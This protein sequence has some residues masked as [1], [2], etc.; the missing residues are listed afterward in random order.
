LFFENNNFILARAPIYFMGILDK[1]RRK[2]KVKLDEP[3]FPAGLSPAMP[4][5]AV[6]PALP[7]PPAPVAPA[8]PTSAMRGS[9]KAELDLVLSQMENVRMQYEAI[10]SR[11]QNIERLVTEIRS[12]CK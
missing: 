6:A 8:V 2:K 5:A 3:K 12:F 10:S 9:V 11:L 7:P 4:R 1:L